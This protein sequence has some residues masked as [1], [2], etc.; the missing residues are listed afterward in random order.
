MVTIVWILVTIILYTQEMKPAMGKPNSTVTIFEEKC[1]PS[2]CSPDGPVVRYPLH[3]KKKPNICSN[4]DLELSCSGNTTVVNLFSGTYNVTRI[5]YWASQIFVALHP[6]GTCITPNNLTL[7]SPSGTPFYYDDSISAAWLNCSTMLTPDNDQI[8]GPI[9]CLGEKGKFVYLVSDLA[10]LDQ[11]KN[12]TRFAETRYLGWSVPQSKSNPDLL[13]AYMYWNT[14]GIPGDCSQCNPPGTECGLWLERNIT[15]CY[16]P[17]SHGQSFFSLSYSMLYVSKFLFP[18][19]ILFLGMRNPFHITLPKSWTFI[20]TISII[21]G[22]MEKMQT[23]R[24]H[25]F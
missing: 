12:C 5:D 6:W 24:I 20:I 4:R 14:S 11:F 19:M 18:S 2:Q 21:G 7:P 15:F 13:E 23:Y 1:P 22:K 16:K 8:K 25:S 10:R 17:P 9:S 3:L